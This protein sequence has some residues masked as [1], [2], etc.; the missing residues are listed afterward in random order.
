MSTP[1]VK[2]AIVTGAAQ[3]IGRAISLRLA[4][5]G[6]NVVVNDIPSKQEQLEKL[7]AEINATQQKGV[8]VVGDVSCEADVRKLVD[9]AVAEF[10]GLDVVSHVFFHSSVLSSS[11]HQHHDRPDGRKCWHCSLHPSYFQ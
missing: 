7:V 2:V 6:L 9:A 10:G 1:T 4:H 8:Y 5:D 3:G 11:Y